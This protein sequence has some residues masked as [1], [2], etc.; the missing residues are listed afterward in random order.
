MG[1]LDGNRL[2]NKAISQHIMQKSSYRHH[3]GMIVAMGESI[4]YVKATHIV[5]GNTKQQPER[6][7]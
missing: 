5:Y 3:T 6:D 2:V 4:L 1:C 7:W